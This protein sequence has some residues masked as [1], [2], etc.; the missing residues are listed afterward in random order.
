MGEANKGD[1]MPEEPRHYRRRFLHN[2]GMAIAAAQFGMIGFADARSNREPSG[3]EG[4][5]TMSQPDQAQSPSEAQGVRPFRADVPEA[6]LVDL[7]RRIAGTR[8]P[9]R[10]T[11]S[12]RSQGVPLP[13]FQELVH[14]WGSDYDWRKAEARLNDWPQFMTTIDGLDIHFL[15]VRSRHPDA[16]PLIMTHGWPGSVLE[17]LKTI[18]PLSDPTASG[19]RA[20][21]AFHLVLPSIPGYGFSGRPQVTGWSHDHVARAWAELMR[22]LGYT[23]YVA[24]GGDYG[25]AIST[26]MARQAPAGLLGIHVN[27][28]LTRPP[29]IAKALASSDAAPA[30]WSAPEKAAYDQLAVFTKTGTGYSAM[31]AT[32]PQTVGYSLADSPAGLAAWMLGHPGF[33][34]WNYRGGDPV[35]LTRDE[36][37]DDITLSW[38]TNTGTSA[39]RFYWEGVMVPPVMDISLPAAFTVF[40]GEIFRAPRSWVERLYRNLIYFHEADKGGHFAAW[41]QPELFSA[42]I[43]AAFRSLR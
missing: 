20:E 42:E 17:L 31:M 22:R 13:E 21:D 29:E 4:E 14:Y 28:L 30:G 3:V 2:A 41:E 9:D 5:H 19:G 18:G 35:P 12:D 32:R 16:L 10:E 43:R 1:T 39:A 25:A 8:W 27:L 6:A 23:R 34:R 40:P 36:V 11:V 33:A 38:V 26:A 7:R 37:L 15:H 24:Q